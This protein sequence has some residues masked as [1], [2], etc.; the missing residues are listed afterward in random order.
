MRAGILARKGQRA[1]PRFDKIT[2]RQRNVIER[3]VGSLQENRQL[4]N[5]Y[6]KLAVHYFATVTLAMI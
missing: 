1:N 5:R 6:A 3:G 4:A 2:W